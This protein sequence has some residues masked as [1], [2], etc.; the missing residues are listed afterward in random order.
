[1]N[2]SG[3]EGFIA[4]ETKYSENLGT[5]VALDSYSI[6]LAPAD[7]PSTGKEV[8]S[9]RKEL[10]EEYKHKIDS[11]SLEDFVGKILKNCPEEYK[12]VFE[13]F[14]DRYLAFGKLLRHG[15]NKD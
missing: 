8:D 9:L 12:D 14:R 1:M 7:H 6:I 3:Q 15:Y 2:E 4:I 5:N 11:I 10:C 13:R